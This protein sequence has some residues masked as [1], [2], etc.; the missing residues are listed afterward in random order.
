MTDAVANKKVKLKGTIKKIIYPRAKNT[1]SDFIVAVF[2]NDRAEV[3]ITGNVYGIREKEEIVI[4]GEWVE[5]KKY[6]QQVKIISWERPVPTSKAQAIE[7]LSS[8]LIKGCGPKTAKLIVDALGDNAIDII[9]A[10]KEA[11]LTPIKGIG[12][13]N[14]SRIVASLSDNFGVQNIIKHLGQYGVT[15]NMAIKLHKMYQSNAVEIIKENPYELTNLSMVGF[16][17]ADIVA[18]NMGI[19]DDSP[20]RCAAAMLHILREQDGHCYTNKNDL[21]QE[22]LKLLN[23]TSSKNLTASNIT[24]A[25]NILDEKRRIRNDN[26]RIY[27]ERI[28]NYEVDSALKLGELMT[29]PC[30]PIPVELVDKEIKHY[31]K[32]HGFILNDKQRQA[33]HETF[34]DNILIITGGP[35]TGKTA[36]TKAIVFIYSRLY[37]HKKI[38][39]C[40]PTGRASQKLAEVVGHEASTIHKLLNW[41]SKE[42]EGSKAAK[43]A[44]NPLEEDL[45]IIDET[46]MVDIELLSALLDAT[47]AGTKLIFIG[48]SDQLPSVGPGAVIRDLINSPIPHVRLTEIY[49]Q[50]K[51][52]FI[53]ENAHRVNNGEM[54]YTNPSRKDFFFIEKRDPDST[55]KCILSC[56]KRLL[57]IGYKPQDILVLSPMKKGLAGTIAIGDAIKELVNPY[58]RKKKEL[59]VGNKA[60]RVGDV[61]IQNQKNNVER[62]LYNGN[63]GVIVNIGPDIYTIIDG[64]TDPEIGLHCIINGDIVFLSR[65]DITEYDINTAYC[66]TTHK[67]QGGQAKVVIAPVL[68]NHYIMLTRNILYTAMTRAEEML[69][70]VGQKKAAYIAIKNVK[71]NMRRTNLAQRIENILKKNSHK[72]LFKTAW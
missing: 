64:D 52:S 3:I 1:D 66:I 14:A 32:I 40:A 24:H 58:S 10:Q 55:V 22:T 61:I 31:H 37:P 18:K 4:K 72:Q 36:T 46:S 45:I 38:A 42:K 20:Y 29:S 33:I 9:M 15:T 39:L 60:F 21:V 17:R 12:K 25:L 57:E 5:H 56:I 23:K 44:N 30:R 41:G 49:R 67:S 7:L 2:G 51:N 26:D 6:G 70:L 62:G 69:I 11:C 35:G 28:Y 19:A 13:N 47:K 27:L 71:P 54:I 50:A 59:I 34:R 43:N 16:D 65:D 8:D 53:I 48:D 63:M 68:T